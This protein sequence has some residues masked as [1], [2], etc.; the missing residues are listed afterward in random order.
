MALVKDMI[1]WER[2]EPMMVRVYSKVYTADE[3]K[4]IAA[5]YRSPPGQ[6]MLAKMPQAMQESMQMLQDLMPRMQQIAQELRG[7]VAKAKSSP[8]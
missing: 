2:M 7:T 8:N 1:S 6:K 3:L 4:D 5:F